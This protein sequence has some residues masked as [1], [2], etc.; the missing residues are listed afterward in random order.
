MINTKNEELVTF[1]YLGTDSVQ[2]RLFNASGTNFSTLIHKLN[3]FWLNTSSRISA[4]PTNFYTYKFDAH[5]RLIF[6]ETNFADFPA[7]FIRMIRDSFYYTNNNIT[8]QKTYTLVNGGRWD[9][10]IYTNTYSDKINT[11]TKKAFGQDFKAL[12]GGLYS[13]LNL[14]GF[15]ALNENLILTQKDETN[16]STTEYTYD[17][18]M[19]DRVIKR[20]KSKDGTVASIRLYSYY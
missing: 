6:A 3:T 5:N 16:N 17:F 14:F 2:E 15:E 18:D 10:V 19:A 13:P 8:T 20:V 12:Y 9:T 4:Y 11:L 7:N 1:K